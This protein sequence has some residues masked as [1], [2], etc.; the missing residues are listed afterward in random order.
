MMQ[1]RKGRK[2]VQSF[3][4][5][6]GQDNDGPTIRPLSTEYQQNKKKIGCDSDVAIIVDVAHMHKSLH[7]TTHVFMLCPQNARTEVP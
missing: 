2:G 6:F 3:Q 4:N 7:S 1:K 5:P